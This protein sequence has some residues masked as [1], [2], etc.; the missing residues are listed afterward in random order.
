MI[1]DS[2]PAAGRPPLMQ[3]KFPE[4]ELVVFGHPHIPLDAAGEALQIPILARRPTGACRRYFAA[5]R[6][7]RRELGGAL[8]A[9]AGTSCAQERHRVRGSAAAAE[10]GA[11]YESNAVKALGGN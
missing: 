11:V 8:F 5:R 4:A 3:A 1:H 7:G 2:D 6:T 9:P 10:L